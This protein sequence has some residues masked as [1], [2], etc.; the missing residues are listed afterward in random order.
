M[1]SEGEGGEKKPEEKAPGEEK[2]EEEK[3]PF[4]IED[5]PLGKGKIVKVTNQTA[6]KLLKADLT[7]ISR[8]LQGTAED[9]EK[10]P[11]LGQLITQHA[12]FQSLIVS[13]GFN[14]FLMV[15][16]YLSVT[17]E[18]LE[19]WRQDSNNLAKDILLT[20]G[21]SLMYVHERDKINAEINAL[22]KRIELLEKENQ[23]YDYLLNLANARIQELVEQIVAIRAALEEGVL[24]NG[25]KKQ[26]ARI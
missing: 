25:G 1:S 3:L 4:E 22:K 17:T 12:Y 6:E 13:L 24:G 5:L 26:S 9:Q 7:F 16:P 19:A 18:K 10:L 23:I 21:E 8:I 2:K 14:V 11:I 20:I 15:A